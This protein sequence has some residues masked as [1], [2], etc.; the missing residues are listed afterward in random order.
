MYDEFQNALNCTL[1][2]LGGLHYGVMLC[3]PR[4]D[5]DQGLSAGDSDDICHLNEARSIYEPFYLIRMFIAELLVN[6]TK[7]KHL[8]DLFT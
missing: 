7:D 3:Y 1:I 5:I 4:S 8:K 6:K 2:V